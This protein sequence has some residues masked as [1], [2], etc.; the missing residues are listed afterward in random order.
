[1]LCTGGAD[2]ACV[3]AVQISVPA[4]IVTIISSLLLFKLAQVA[5]VYAAVGVRKAAASARRYWGVQRPSGTSTAG[6]GDSEIPTAGIRS[7]S[8]DLS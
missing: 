7:G 6:E 5:I 8:A 1:M 4:N 3:T 2:I